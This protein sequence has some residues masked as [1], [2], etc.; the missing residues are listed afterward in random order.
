MRAGA[1]LPPG[2]ARLLF[3]QSFPCPATSVAAVAIVA[4]FLLLPLLLCR[5]S[6][7]VHASGRPSC[8]FTL[9]RRRA[10]RAASAGPAGSLRWS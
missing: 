7:D 8:G 5:L 4:A 3:R 9:A 10:A 1:A 2:G 6:V